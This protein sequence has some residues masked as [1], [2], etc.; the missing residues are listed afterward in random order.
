MKKLLF[1]LFFTYISAAVFGFMVQPL[2]QTIQANPNEE[3]EIEF[4]LSNTTNS[5]ETI[6]II[7]KGVYI[8]PAGKGWIYDDSYER[9]FVSWITVPNELRKNP[10]PT[11]Q[12][13][14]S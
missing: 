14:G 4:I 2:I 9:S 11:V 3:K 6:S 13:G 1:I 10:R 8:D 7:T 5:P 12:S